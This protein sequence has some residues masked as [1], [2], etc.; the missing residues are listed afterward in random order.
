MYIVYDY[1]YDYGYE[2]EIYIFLTSQIN[3]IYIYM[4]I[5]E[6]LSNRNLRHMLQYKITYIPYIYC[7]Y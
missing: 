6:K 1:D 3:K 5:R 7:T 2:Y 4:Y